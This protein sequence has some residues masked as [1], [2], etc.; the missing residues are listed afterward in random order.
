MSVRTRFTASSAAVAL[1]VAGVTA[2]FASTAN[3][4]E[5]ESTP[6][7]VTTSEVT[8]TPTPTSEEAP[9]AV[10]SMTITPDSLSTVDW[11]NPEMGIL[12]EAQGFTPGE[13]VVITAT[14]LGDNFDVTT[15][16]ADDL[17]AI[18]LRIWLEGASEPGTVTVQAVGE[19][20]GV[21]VSASAT[22]TGD[23]IPPTTVVPDEVG[24]VDAPSAKTGLPVVSG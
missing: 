22:V 16:T 12:I 2:G 19:T 20:S 4:A 18:A 5:D 11:Q 1:L 7:A 15:T 3:A 13:N 24:A 21:T 10:A 6:P 14:Y 8:E 23:V 17:G 9:A